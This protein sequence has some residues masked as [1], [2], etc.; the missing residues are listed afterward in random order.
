[1]TRRSMVAANGAWGVALTG[2][3]KPSSGAI[4]QR[5]LKRGQKDG[6]HIHFTG[7]ER[8]GR[9]T[10][11][12]TS[13]PSRPGTQGPDCLG[14]SSHVGGLP[15]KADLQRYLPFGTARLEQKAFA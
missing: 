9:Q 10:S 2:P 11:F 4:D 14:N 3:A 7:A 5:R 8:G 6:T 12:R 1:M 13:R 15:I